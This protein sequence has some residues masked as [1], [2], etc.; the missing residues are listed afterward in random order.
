[1]VEQKKKTYTFS[2]PVARSPRKSPPKDYK[3]KSPAAEEEQIS[4]EDFENYNVPKPFIQFLN[5]VSTS[6]SAKFR[7]LVPQPIDVWYDDGREGTYQGNLEL[8]KEYTVNSYEGHVFYFTA[9]GNKNKVFARHT[10]S[11]DQVRGELSRFYE[12]N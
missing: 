8:G 4:E 12:M 5:R 3:R 6:A 10:V 1:V 7:S 2:P 11:Q 9:K